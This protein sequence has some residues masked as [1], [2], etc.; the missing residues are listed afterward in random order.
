MSKYSSLNW[1]VDL[2]KNWEGELEND[3]H[4][5]YDPDGVG[6]LQISAYIKTDGA[7]TE[8]EILERT[9]LDENKHS[10][11]LQSEWGQFHGYHLI[12]R[13]GDTFWK[14]WW[15]AKGNVFL[16]I[17]YNCDIADKDIEFKTIDMIL[18]SLR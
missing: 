12:F 17:T 9:E 6:A 16:F 5:F 15:L 18:S 10:H 7:I 8:K 4:L 13:E 3:I 14:N 1:E 11:L 2:P